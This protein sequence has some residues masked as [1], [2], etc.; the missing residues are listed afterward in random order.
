MKESLTIFN[1]ETLQSQEKVIPFESIKEVNSLE[2]FV[3]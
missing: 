2:G 3:I 1:D